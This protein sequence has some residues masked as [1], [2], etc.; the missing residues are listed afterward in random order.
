MFLKV[1]VSITDVHSAFCILTYSYSTVN[2]NCEHLSLHTSYI[3]K[4][5]IGLISIT[6][7]VLLFAFICVVMSNFVISCNGEKTHKIYKNALYR[8]LI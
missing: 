2:L 5:R 1:T 4:L 8:S 3:S 6:S 7:M